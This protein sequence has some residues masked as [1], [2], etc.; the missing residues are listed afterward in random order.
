MLLFNSVS[1]RHLF[2]FYGEESKVGN[3]IIKNV[4][5]NR[6]LILVCQISTGTDELL[7]YT[8]T[9]DNRDLQKDSRFSILIWG[10]LFIRNVRKDDKGTY[11]CV[12]KTFGDKTFPKIYKGKIIHLDVLCMLML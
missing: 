4:V 9:R 12:A 11:N 2:L 5:V 8:W 3:P 6:S 10:G 7:Q 1:S